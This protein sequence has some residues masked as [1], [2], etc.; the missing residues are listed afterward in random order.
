MN[1]SSSAPKINTTASFARYVGLSRSTIS[2]VLNKQDGLSQRTINRVH[3]AMAETGFTVNAHAA[4]LRKRRTATIGVCMEDFLTPTAVSKLSCLQ[5]HLRARGCTTLIEVMRPGASLQVVQH[6]LS[7]RVDGV[8]FI[9]HFPPEE[10]GARL[11][12]L[13]KHEVPHLIVD[14]AGLKGTH[15]VTLDRVAALSEVMRHLLDLGHRSFGLLGISGAHQTVS[16]RLT[17]I[18]A[19]LIERGLDPVASLRSLDDQHTRTKHFDFGRTLAGAFARQP[20]RPTA[21]VAVNDE[22]AIG[23]LLA[24]QEFGLQVPRDLSIVGF[25]NQNICLMTRPQLTSVD[26]QVETTMH[27]AADQ[28]LE[29][30]NGDFATAQPGLDLIRALFVNRGSTGPVH[31]PGQVLVGD[32]LPR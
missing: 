32:I 19:A 25:D 15:T 4:N 24:F 13:R 29:L 18:R 6:L 28:I 31:P 10:L 9:G 1:T 7:L 20:E 5:E 30:V 23:A 17:G 16:D 22:T 12:E 27:R 14:H 8:I 3:Q 11:A 2:R 26:Q 21:F